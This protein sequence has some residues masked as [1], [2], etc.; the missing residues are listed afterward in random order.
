MLAVVC[1]GASSGHVLAA[2]V[3]PL[4]LRSRG[5]DCQMALAPTWSTLLVVGDI[6]VNLSVTGPTSGA[7]VDALRNGGQLAAIREILMGPVRVLAGSERE[8]DANEPGK[9]LP[10]PET[11]AAAAAGPMPSAPAPAAGHVV[12]EWRVERASLAGCD[13]GR[14]LRGEITVVPK[15]NKEGLPNNKYWVLIQCR[16]VECEGVQ[17]SRVYLREC[18]PVQA[19]QLYQRW[20]PAAPRVLD[21]NEKPNARAVFHGWGSLEEVQSYCLA[22]GFAVACERR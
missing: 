18:V 13:A 4:R 12:P 17:D 22:A 16:P 11:A 19:P 6:Q 8:V 9:V 3:S 20:A 5:T 1:K 10:P 14:K 7:V 2:V 15:T 21:V